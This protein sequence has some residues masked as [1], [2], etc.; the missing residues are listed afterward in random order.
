[1]TDTKRTISQAGI[2][3]SAAAQTYQ[4]TLASLLKATENADHLRA[5]GKTWVDVAWSM[6]DVAWASQAEPA[7]E[8]QQKAAERNAA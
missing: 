3:R 4:A 7:C 6:V 1:M 5:T 2:N 8:N